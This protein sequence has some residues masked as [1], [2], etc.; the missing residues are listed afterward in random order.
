MA[1]G[2]GLGSDVPP[3]NGL[4]TDQSSLPYEEPRS[5]SGSI[6]AKGADGEEPLF[7]FR[8]HAH[9]SG[10]KLVVDREYLYPD[11][12]PAAEEKA[13]YEG[14]SLVSYVLNEVQIGALGSLEIHY[15]S[16]QPPKG[17]VEFTY[18]A[19]PGGKVKTHRENLAP[20]TL[21]ADMVGPFLLA[22]WQALAEGQSVRCRYLVIPRRE[23]VGFTFTRAGE[24]VWRGRPVVLV[25]MEVTSPLLSPL[26]KPLIFTIEQAPPHRVLQYTGRTTPRLKTDGK[27]KDFDAVTIFDWEPATPKKPS[28]P[29]G[30]N[31]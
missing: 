5:L 9:R 23:T 18:R 12:R 3:T 7:R 19:E 14:D 30:Q 20:D 16:R 6:Y 25:R 29:S 28:Q 4:A 22:H 27:W 26:V 10:D 24:S 8:R 1:L 2:A 17:T 11:G 21:T 13:V 15:T 31:P